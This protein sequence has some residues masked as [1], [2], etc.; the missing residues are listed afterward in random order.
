MD[1]SGKNMSGGRY[2]KERL[3]QKDFPPE[4]F[5]ERRK[6]ILDAIGPEA[7]ALLQGKPQVR[8][9]YLFRQSNDFYYCCGVEIP[10]SY[11][12]IDGRDRATRL[13]IPVF[14]SEGG[15]GENTLTLE[16]ADLI[17]EFTGID[18]VL[19][20]DKLMDYLKNVKT[21]YVPH[22]P[23]EDRA[24]TKY[25]I[26]YSNR[27]IALD[28]WDGGISR[29]QRFIS[30][31]RARFPHIVIKDLTPILDSLRLVK[32]E[33]E[34]RVL[35][36]AGRLAALAVTEAMRITK[37]GIMEYHLRAVANYIFIAHGATG[38][39]YRAIV[40]S[41]ENI[42]DPHY[43]RD[44]SVLKDGD[45]VLMDVAPDYHYYT[46]DIG[47][48][49]P[50]N[51]KYS[52]WQ[53]ELYGF[54]VEYH[55]TLLKTIRP[56]L[57]ADEILKITAEEMSDYIKKHSFSKEIYRKAAEKTLEFKGHLSHT[58]GMAVHDVGDY[59]SIPLK[60]GIVFSVDPQMWI[61]EEKLYIRVEDTIVVTNNGVE[62]LTGSAPLELD[63][64]E[65]TMREKSLF[66]TDLRSLDI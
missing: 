11:L 40:A 42:W 19:P 32:S 17:K 27:L 52:P 24:E 30:L 1:V 20:L 23:A 5:K 49:W 16:D 36:K 2:G 34:I 29:E 21:I 55:K 6:K 25:T 53:R 22:G 46:S 48:M 8:G 37:P 59:R 51:G 62:A 65:T 66:F 28:P 31:L 12:L 64:V 56:G 9:F 15:S 41:G 43:F 38:E 26:L 35:R 58:V 3:F 18:E 44:D 14:L 47:R 60:P 57:T 61:P 50:V 33:R 54:I 13:F 7:C 45:L 10:H 63:D 39:G 4:E